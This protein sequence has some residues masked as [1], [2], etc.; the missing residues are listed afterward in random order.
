MR[1]EV[2]TARIAVALI[3]DVHRICVGEPDSEGKDVSGVGGEIGIEAL[4]NAH[5]VRSHALGLQHRRIVGDPRVRQRGAWLRKTDA[6]GG[7]GLAGSIDEV[8]GVDA[9]TAAALGEIDDVVENRQPPEVGVFAD[10]IRSVAELSDIEAPD[11]G[12]KSR[13]LKRLWLEQRRDD[14]STRSENDTGRL[15][16]AP[17]TGVPCRIKHVLL[18]IEDGRT[19]VIAAV[20]VGFREVELPEGIELR[21][22]AVNRLR[23]RIS[24]IDDERRVGVGNIQH[25]DRGN[26]AHEG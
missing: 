14:L 25:I 20:R 16:S 17:I 4:Q 2:E 18:A 15:S 26:I 8:N 22:G 12:W 23:Y 24:R 1:I 5:V 11:R 13:G 19:P 10:L 7:A 21:D 6:R 3:R 9:V